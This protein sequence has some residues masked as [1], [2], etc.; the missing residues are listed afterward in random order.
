MEE[1]VE[2][3]VKASRRAYDN[4]RLFMIG[5][6]NSLRRLGCDGTVNC[7]KDGIREIK[8]NNDKLNTVVCGVPP[9]MKEK[10][11]RG[12]AWMDLRE[13]TNRKLK[14]EVEL[15]RD[16]GYRV[17]FLSLDHHLLDGR[18]YK[19]DGTHLN[20]DGLKALGKCIVSVLKK[21]SHRGSSPP[22]RRR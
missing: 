10:A 21:R 22:S 2:E 3:A 5:G 17:S 19:E 13:R 14:A 8:G 6:G 15:M 12:E 16:N 20:N 11:V 7:V 1:V 18:L 9:R 4:T